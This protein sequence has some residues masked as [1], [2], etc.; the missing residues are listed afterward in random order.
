MVIRFGEWLVDQ[1]YR[2]DL[3]GNLARLPIIHLGDQKSS[4]RKPNEHNIWADIVIG[5]SQP[6]YI[7]VF[8]DAWQEFLLAKQAA[9][10]SLD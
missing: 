8:N 9:E 4:R 3:I 5:I 1:Q 6:G 2:Q 7:P 10:D